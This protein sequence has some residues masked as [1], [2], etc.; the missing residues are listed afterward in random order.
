MKYIWP[1]FL[2][3]SLFGCSNKTKTTD[4][5][6]PKPLSSA[7]LIAF[8]DTIYRAEQEPIRLR[9]SLAEKFGMESEERRIQNEIYKK[10]HILNEAKIKGLLSN[11]GWPSKDSI[12]ELGSLTICNVLQHSS[13]EVRVQFL[14]MM[15]EAVLSKKLDPRFLVRAEDRIATDRGDLQIYGGQVKYYPETKRFDVW[16]VYDPVNIDKRRAKI[17]LGPIAEHLKNR[18][19]IPWDLEEQ[20]K[21]SEEFVKNRNRNK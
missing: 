9:D 13:P 10:N 6:H 12:G 1:F 15:R 4:L 17:G 2:L 11:Y 5:A 7:Y 16:P 14:P 8:L 3:I 18:F 19:N 20:I 21:R